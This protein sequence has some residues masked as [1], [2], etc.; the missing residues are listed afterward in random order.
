MQKKRINA[1]M[2]IAISAAAVA[3]CTGGTETAEGEEIVGSAEVTDPIAT[4]SDMTA[5]MPA[6]VADPADKDGFF[7]LLL[8]P[9][10]DVEDEILPKDVILVLDKSGSMEG[11]KFQQAQEALIYI[12]EHLNEDDR[13]NVITFSTGLD[14][15][16]SRLRDAD[17]ADEAVEWVERQEALG[18]TD[19]NRALLEAVAMADDDRP[20]YIIFLTDGLPT[21]GETKSE[22]IINNMQDNAPRNVRLFAFGVG[23]DVDTFLLDSLAQEPPLPC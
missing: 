6:T 11:E 21:E 9:R 16:A 18:A 12:L 7:M 15:Y 22:R 13:F 3:G 17:E 23:Y 8:A 20:T 14:S 10:P 2:A 4:E 1:I 5:E 19:I